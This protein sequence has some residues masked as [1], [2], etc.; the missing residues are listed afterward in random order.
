VAGIADRVMVMYAGQVVEHGPV[1][2]IFADPRHPYT[3][4]LLGTVPS[5][6]G[7]RARRLRTIEGQPPILVAPPSAC[8][9][10]PRCERAFNRCRVE[11]PKRRQISATHDVACFW[12]AATGEPVHD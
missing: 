6:V 12:D 5:V 11:N 8:A 2:E 3:R 9:F 7:P 1:A 10:A 4:A